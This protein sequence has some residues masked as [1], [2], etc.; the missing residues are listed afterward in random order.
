MHELW[1]SMSFK[2]N[3]CVEPD[4]GGKMIYESNSIRRVK[5]H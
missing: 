3:H 2:M 4:W 1:C 5:C